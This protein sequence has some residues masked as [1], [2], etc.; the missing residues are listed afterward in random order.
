M[1][2]PQGIYPSKTSEQ[3]YRSS[4]LILEG[5]EESSGQTR[6][7]KSAGPRTRRTAS[8][9]Q[10][11]HRKKRFVSKHKRSDPH[12]RDPSVFASAL[13]D[14]QLASSA[15]R[16]RRMGLPYM[17]LGLAMPQAKDA[18][19]SG[20]PHTS[21]E[22]TKLSSS[23]TILD[24]PK[25]PQRLSG[26][27]IEPV[28][29]IRHRRDSGSEPTRGTNS[30]GVDTIPIRW[31]RQVDDND[32]EDENGDYDGSEEDDDNDDEGSNLDISLSRK[33][34]AK[35]SS[36][37]DDDD[38]EDGRS[39]QPDSKPT[40]ERSKRL[41][42]TDIDSDDDDDA[43]LDE[44]V[45]ET[46]EDDDE[47]DD[48]GDGFSAVINEP[49]APYFQQNKRVLR[50]R[51]NSDDNTDEDDDDKDT[52]KSTLNEMLDEMVDNE[53]GL[54][55][56]ALRRR[57]RSTN[58]P[59]SEWQLSRDRRSAPVIRQILQMADEEADEDEEEEEIMADDVLS[60]RKRD[61]TAPV[62]QHR[63]KRDGDVEAE[64]DLLEIDEEFDGD[65]DNNEDFT[66]DE[67]TKLH[68]IALDMAAD[69][70]RG[71][72]DENE[73]E[74]A[75]EDTLNHVIKVRRDI[76]ESKSNHQVKTEKA[77]MTTKQSTHK[78]AALAKSHASSQKQVTQNQLHQQPQN[79]YRV[80]PSTDRN[81]QAR[82]RQQGSSMFRGQPLDSHK[83]VGLTTSFRSVSRS[84][85]DPIVASF[86]L[87]SVGNSAVGTRVA[88]GMQVPAHSSANHKQRLANTMDAQKWPETLLLE[89]LYK[90]FKNNETKSLL[91]NEVML[92]LSNLVGSSNIPGT[93][94]EKNVTENISM[95][96][97]ISNS[98]EINIQ[99]MKIPTLTEKTIDA[100]KHTSQAETSEKQPKSWKVNH[101]SEPLFENETSSVFSKPPNVYYTS[102]QFPKVGTSKEST[103]SHVNMKTSKGREAASSD[104][105][106]VLQSYTFS[107]KS[108]VPG[109]AIKA[110][111][112]N[113]EGIHARSQTGP[114][115]V[116]ISLP[117]NAL[118]ETNQGDIHRDRN[119]RHKRSIPYD[120]KSDPFQQRA[121][122]I[123]P[124]RDEDD[125][126]DVV[127]KYKDA[128]R[129]LEDIL[130]NA[131]GPVSN[132]VPAPQTLNV[133]NNPD[134]DYDVDEDDD[135]DFDTGSENLQEVARMLKRQ[136]Q[137]S[138]FT[139]L[140]DVSGIK[141]EKNRAK[142]TVRLEKARAKGA[143]QNEKLK[144][145]KDLAQA[146]KMAQ[147]QLAFE[148]KKAE[149]AIRNEKENAKMAIR[150]EERKA[151]ERITALLD[152]SAGRHTRETATTDPEDELK[153]G[154]EAGT[155]EYM[156]IH[157]DELV[158]YENT[159][160]LVHSGYPSGSGIQKSGDE[161]DRIVKETAVNVEAAVHNILKHADV[162]VR[163]TRDV[164]QDVF[165]ELF[166][167]EMD[168]ESDKKVSPSTTETKSVVNTENVNFYN[169]DDDFELDDN[170]D[171]TDREK[172]N[173]A[174]Q[175]DT[176]EDSKPALKASKNGRSSEFY[177]ENDGNDAT[178][179]SSKQ[180]D[181]YDY[182]L[183]T[184]KDLQ[185]MK[186]SSDKQE[187]A[188]DDDD[189]DD[190][191]ADEG[192]GNKEIMPGEMMKSIQVSKLESDGQNKDEEPEEALVFEEEDDDGPNSGRYF[193][194]TSVT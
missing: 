166:K 105:G 168:K 95:G 73:N 21:E 28:S 6:Q 74:E 15:K 170:E 22:T 104:T 46:G 96:N 174:D 125:P 172:R 4:S 161:K 175:K 188:P 79:T 178:A 148:Q 101:K 16:Q 97:N 83:F 89:A 20:G 136:K 23:Q 167:P 171:D 150:Q 24:K 62:K 84:Q 52:L 185:M 121:T 158:G 116:Y 91:M 60:R 72:S 114:K 180:E 139:A 90:T 163:R 30:L 112:R 50:E 55:E 117:E 127:T 165:K 77:R 118:R 3:R 64:S 61:V 110:K 94:D 138:Q 151:K 37:A 36:S 194:L 82:K 49:G 164:E 13:N 26:V 80:Q 35:P 69:S 107:P 81:P 152:S 29:S 156:H 131:L 119:R 51:P 5:D 2:D 130:N 145:E 66:E 144:V 78:E 86:A 141:R 128:D 53:D 147:E 103:M 67:Q 45:N 159:E 27:A 63:L 41:L 76:E 102:Q 88:A 191:D 39:D 190:D 123:Q 181:W 176:T 143:L 135:D 68:N 43:A 140:S 7:K 183:P 146:N 42:D 56:V 100:T 25:S 129:T 133:Q 85:P 106:N 154:R 12:V 10:T 8:L 184:K 149:E 11:T 14:G 38:Q 120:Q 155:Q 57:K 47:I 109:I 98:N 87:G 71:D 44:R 33:R 99:N 186:R 187:P 157:P 153:Q 115:T 179:T 126:Q 34:R 122:L 132:P 124:E 142:N 9:H 113:K 18:K 182:E 65:G 169:A 192:D 54:T 70:I 59:S 17:L 177:F 31:P 40:A 92:L 173:T 189:N 162:N 1:D 19:V 75:E 48:D 137:G 108:Q 93:V 193:L 160:T 134:D 111:A 58:R 32:D